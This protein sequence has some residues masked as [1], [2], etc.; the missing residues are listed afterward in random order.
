M[1]ITERTLNTP[2]IRNGIAINLEDGKTVEVRVE[3]GKEAI[4]ILLK[5]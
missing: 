2:G 4:E 3:G 1:F 5:N